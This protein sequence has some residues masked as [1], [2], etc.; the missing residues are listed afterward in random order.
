MP[1]NW[2]KAQ[3]ARV[4]ARAKAG[5]SSAQRDLATMLASG[6]LG[7]PNHRQA[8]KWYLKSAEAGDDDAQYNLGLMYILGEGVRK[9]RDTGLRWLKAAARNENDV[10]EE[11]LGQIYERGAFGFRKNLRVALKWYRAAATR[12]NNKAKFGLGLCLSLKGTPSQRKEGA[13]LIRQA[14]RAGVVDAKKYLTEKRA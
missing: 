3:I 2:T 8:F 12:G 9:N 1:A 7:A 4:R 6:A 13:R 11:V 10:A 5:D 14:A